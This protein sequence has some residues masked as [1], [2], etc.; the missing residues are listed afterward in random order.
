MQAWR[1]RR[2]HKKRKSRSLKRIIFLSGAAKYQISGKKSTD[3]KLRK[4]SK[5]KIKKISAPSPCRDSRR[6]F[7][8]AAALADFRKAQ[9]QHGY[10]IFSAN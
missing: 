3:L 9:E 1:L 7:W 6:L 8:L 4:T 10:E 5:N 2:R